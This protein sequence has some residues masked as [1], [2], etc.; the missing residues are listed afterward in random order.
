MD[1]KLYK[2]PEEGMLTGL[3][4]GLAEYFNIDVTVV[5]LF[6]VLLAFLSGG[7]LVI[8]YIIGAIIVPAKNRVVAKESVDE[9]VNAT[10]KDLTDKVS[11]VKFRNW[12]GVGLVLLGSWLLLRSLWPD[13]FAFRWDIVWPVVLIF[14]G[15]MVIIRGRK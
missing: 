15:V 9:R 13:W 5:R 1:K 2:I 7:F 14:I 8:V 11:T 6:A 12:F 4:A 3:C 10:A